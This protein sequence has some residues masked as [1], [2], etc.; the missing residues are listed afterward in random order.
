MGRGYRRFGPDACFLF[1]RD[2]EGRPSKIRFPVSCRRR[3]GSTRDSTIRRSN[4]TSKVAERTPFAAARTPVTLPVETP[5][6]LW[7]RG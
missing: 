1:Q 4:A 6:S 3:A 5:L 2:T 7:M